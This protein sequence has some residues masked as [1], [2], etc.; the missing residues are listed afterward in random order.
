[1]SRIGPAKSVKIKILWM[2]KEIAALNIYQGNLL[3]NIRVKHDFD[4]SL[5]ICN[6]TGKKMLF[7]FKN[8]RN[9][10]ACVHYFLSNVYFL[11]TR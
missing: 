8:F 7:F 6:W 4:L 10:K 9:L 1:M 2:F 5:K 3:E 11:I